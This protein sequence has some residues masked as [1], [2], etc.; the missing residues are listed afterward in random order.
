MIV[1]VT[2]QGEVIENYNT[3]RGI[4]DKRVGRGGGGRGVSTSCD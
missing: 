1:A 4:I 3:R 2:E